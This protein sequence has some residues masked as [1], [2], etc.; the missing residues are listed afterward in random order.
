MRFGSSTEWS[1]AWQVKHE[2]HII[3]PLNT[4]PKEPEPISSIVTKSL[5][6]LCTA[7]PAIFPD[8]LWADQRMMSSAPRTLHHER[9]S[10]YAMI[11]PIAMLYNHAVELLVS[12]CLLKELLEEHGEQVGWPHKSKAIRVSLFHALE[13]DIIDHKICN[14]PASRITQCWPSWGIILS[15]IAVFCNDQDTLW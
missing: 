11:V 14:Y 1:N 3:W 8:H 4:L 10:N 7:S 6:L 13:Y 9:K 12:T 5:I 15:N 2:R